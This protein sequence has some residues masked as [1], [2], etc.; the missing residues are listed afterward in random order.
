MNDVAVAILEPEVRELQTRAATWPERAKELDVDD[1]GSFEFASSLLLDVS[2]LRKEIEGH[3]RPLRDAAHA[4]HK[5]ICDKEN[6]LKAPLVE[7]EKLLKPKMAAFLEAQEKERRRLE[8]EATARQRAVDEANRAAEVAALEK[9]GEHEA[10]QQ[11]AEAPPSPPVVIAS[12]A[13]KV[14]GVSSRVVWKA[15]ITD[16]DAFFKAMADNKQMRSVVEIKDGALNRVAAQF[17]GELNWPGVEV[18]TDRSIVRR[19]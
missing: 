19:G 7:A 5:K 6:E 10:A 18:Y 13:P 12:L 11:V 2:A 1:A 4:A 15:R 17:Q 8:A 14:D 16:P 9:A 3:F